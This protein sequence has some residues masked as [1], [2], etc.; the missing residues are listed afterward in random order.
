[1]TLPAT[2]RIELLRELL[3]EGYVIATQAELTRATGADLLTEQEVAME[4]HVA[5]ATLRKWRTT[6]EGPL[7]VKVPGFRA[8]QYRRCDLE[9]WK[10]HLPGWR[11]SL[12]CRTA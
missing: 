5:I 11:S 7:F 3:P 1:M 2:L 10:A 9:E 6:G 8:P 4:L 12:E